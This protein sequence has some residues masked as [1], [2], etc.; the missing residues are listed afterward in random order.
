MARV[1]RRPIRL[2][3]WWAGFI[4]AS[5]AVLAVGRGLGSAT[6]SQITV[7]GM[8][9]GMAKSMLRTKQVPY[10][11][12][13]LSSYSTGVHLAMG[14]PE[15]ILNKLYETSG[16]SLGYFLTHSAQPSDIPANPYVRTT[17]Q[18]LP[19]GKSYEEVLYDKIRA[20]NGN[21]TPG[22]ILRMSLEATNGDY[23]VA[24]LTAHNLLK[25]VAYGEA[26]GT[27]GWDRGAR[28]SM[29]T[30]KVIR[31]DQVLDKLINLRPAGDK[32]IS[33][34][35]GP[36][37]HMFGV[38]FVGGV[39]NPSTAANMA[40]FENLTR[41]IHLGSDPDPTKEAINTASGAIGAMLADLAANG[42]LVP[43]DL[44]KL[45]DAELSDLRAKLRAFHESSRKKM[46]A[47]SNNPQMANTLRG[48]QKAIADEV[49][50]A[51]KEIRRRKD[52][53]K[54]KDPAAAPGA[55]WVLTGI[56]VPKVP[57]WIGDRDPK[58]F[59]RF[60]ID[61]GDGSL[62]VENS[63]NDMG[64]KVLTC[65]TVLQW[66]IKEPIAKL[67]PGA[68]LHISGSCAM[69]GLQDR[70]SFGCHWQPTGMRPG[71]SHTSGIGI[72]SKDLAG[73]GARATFEAVATVPPKSA[74]NGTMVLRFLAYARGYGAVEY[75]YK[76]V[77]K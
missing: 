60:K 48:L 7:E 42:P 43:D 2:A 8:A 25:E 69:S 55:G 6:Q 64:Y 38:F 73:T 40:A 68:Q 62:S 17:K 19:N 37:Y 21:L 47:M 46:E 26:S 16:R 77:D 67:K 33:D 13:P 12:S 61:G 50:R 28:V 29:K 31:P 3:S 39:S 5:L 4:L 34:K 66:R 54:P 56:N 35:D 63:W 71:D 72:Y 23:Y 30:A 36:W 57:D 27:I 32:N 22:D 49:G 20:S 14:V 44:S 52:L 15:K 70:T 18:R 41:K 65:T 76:W 74:Y 1:H 53:N 24:T 9:A 75:V 10:S 11:K 59:S 58:R 45:T 51:D